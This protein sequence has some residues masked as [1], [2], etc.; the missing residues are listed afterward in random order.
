MDLWGTGDKGLDMALVALSAA[1]PVEAAAVVPRLSEWFSRSQPPLRTVLGLAL[2]Y[3]SSAEAAARQIVEDV[4][5][6]ARRG[7]RIAHLPEQ[8]DA[9]R[10]YLL[11]SY[12]Y[13]PVLDAIHVARRLQRGAEEQTAEFSGIRGFLMTLMD[14]GGDRLINYPPQ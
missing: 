13:S 2:G 11:E 4:T 7:R 6:V 5:W 3:H 1:F 14:L 9:P 10:D 8:A 12:I